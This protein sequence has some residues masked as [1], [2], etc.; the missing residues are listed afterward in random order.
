MPTKT[1]SQREP[2]AFSPREFAALFKKEQSWGYRQIYAGK[3]KTITEY[4]RILVPAS[5]VERILASAARYEGTKKKPARTKAELQ[6]M[7]PALQSAWQ[8]FVAK[9]RASG[10]KPVKR[11]ASPPR[12]AVN[13]PDARKAA[14]DRLT[15]RKDDSGRGL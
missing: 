11:V 8:T 9:A 3:V 2:V 12:S 1:S 6:A 13:R 5:E 7:K 14:I 10:A 15:R 4:G